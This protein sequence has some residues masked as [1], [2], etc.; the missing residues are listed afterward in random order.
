[1]SPPL[2]FQGRGAG[3]LGSERRAIYVNR[4]NRCV[5]PHHRAFGQKSEIRVLGIFFRIN[6][7]DA[8]YGCS[9]G[10]ASDEKPET[11]ELATVKVE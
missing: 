5:K 3:G 4:S 8:D 7:S 2:P 1:M 9:A 6:P 10:F 11:A